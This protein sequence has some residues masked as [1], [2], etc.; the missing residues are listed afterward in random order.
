LQIADNVVTQKLSAEME[1]VVANVDKLDH[2]AEKRGPF[3][4]SADDEQRLNAFNAQVL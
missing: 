1:A 2:V 4:W 3:S